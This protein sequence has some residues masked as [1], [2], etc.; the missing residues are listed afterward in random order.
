MEGKYEY[1]PQVLNDPSIQELSEEYTR[2]KAE[3]DN[4]SVVYGPNYP[5]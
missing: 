4:M 2:V 1:L 5:T 3:Y